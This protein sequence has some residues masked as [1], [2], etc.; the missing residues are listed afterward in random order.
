MQASKKIAVAGATGRV[1]R[2]LATHPRGLI[3]PDVQE[4]LCRE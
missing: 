2:R 3:C 1:A 4:E